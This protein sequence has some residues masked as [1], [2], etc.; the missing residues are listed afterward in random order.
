MKAER[1]SRRVVY[2]S[3]WVNLYLDKVRLPNGVMINPFHLLDFPRSA[4]AALVEDDQGRL[5]LCR[6]Y[7]YST[8]IEEWELPAGGVEAGEEVLDAA[9]REV[10]EETGL[11][12]EG[13]A[14]LYS[15]YPQNGLGNKV[16]HVVHCRSGRQ[17]SQPDPAE[18]AETRWFE[19][20][21]IEKMLAERYF[22]D[23]FTL[24]A[25]LLWLMGKEGA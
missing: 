13:H 6:I 25:L 15:Y 8:D 11:E 21:E 17:T 19:R 7:R 2:E 10:W 9:R 12:S 20:Q 16:F 14:L 22:S 5:I 4:V 1:L 3:G 23:G 18:V 24:T